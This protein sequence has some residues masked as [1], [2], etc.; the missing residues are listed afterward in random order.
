MKQQFLA[1]FLLALLVAFAACSWPPVEPS[2][3]AAGHPALSAQDM[4]IPCSSCHQEVTPGVYSEWYAST[5]GLDNVK[6]YQCHGTYE[7]LSVT[8]DMDRSCGACHANKLGDHTGNRLCWD[9][10]TP[11]SFTYAE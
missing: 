5:H 10:H 8:P 11:H 6:C 3:V 2:V 4:L 7:N 1:L 9:C